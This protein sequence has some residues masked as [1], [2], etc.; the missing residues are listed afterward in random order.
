MSTTL[1]QSQT[2]VYTNTIRALPRFIE[3]VKT[4]YTNLG[5]LNINIPPRLREDFEKFMKDDIEWLKL[6][7]YPDP[8]VVSYLEAAFQRMSSWLTDW[9]PLAFMPLDCEVKEGLMSSFEA[10]LRGIKIAVLSSILFRSNNP[11]DEVHNLANS[12]YLAHRNAPLQ[13]LVLQ[14][15]KDDFKS[16]V[17]NKGK[18]FI[19]WNELMQL[20]RNDLAMYT[21]TGI[22]RV[23]EQEIKKHLGMQN[24][25]ISLDVLD[26]FFTYIWSSIDHFR[27]FIN[28]NYLYGLIEVGLENNFTNYTELQNQFNS[29]IESVRLVITRSSFQ[30]YQQKEFIIGVEG[31]DN[32]KRQVKDRIITLG[33]DDSNEFFNDVA[34][35]NIIGNIDNIFAFIYVN[36]RGYNLVDISHRGIVKMKVGDIPIRLYEGMFLVFGSR[37]LILVSIGGGLLRI[38]GQNK[39]MLTLKGVSSS[40][41]HITGYTTETSNECV[42]IGRT[43]ENRIRINAEDISEKH[44]ECYSQGEDWYLRELGSTFGTYYR[45]KNKEQIDQRIP[46]ESVLLDR[47]SIFSVEDFTFIILPID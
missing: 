29:N 12:T 3:D 6:V 43:P 28:R 19:R 2:L 8:S 25:V 1:N 24:E 34:L 18:T 7:K 39:K 30:E 42:T 27:R 36:S 21:Q 16:N 15:K 35:P 31:A 40:T 33:K 10:S 26:N 45:L 4:Q 20:M 32:S 22:N 47:Y 5:I 13:W 37:S 11:I 46:S 9:V 23:Y 41:G 44:A 17:M 38:G 14:G